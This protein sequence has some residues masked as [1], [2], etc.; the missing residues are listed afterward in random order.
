MTVPGEFDSIRPYNDEETVAALHRVARH[1]FYPLI[2]KYLF[3]NRTVADCRR[4]LL[5][6][7]GVDDFQKRVMYNVVKAII[8]KTTDGFS[9]SGIE[10]I[11]DIDGKFVAITNHRDIVLDPALLEYTLLD[12]GL[13]GSQIC[14]GNN[15]IKTQLIKDLMLS[16]RSITV[17]RNSNPRML[18]ERSRL[19]SAY[20]RNSVTC[21]GRAVWI[22]QREGRAKDGNDL[23]AQ[24][25]LKMLNMSGEGNFVENF[26]E[27]K[28]VPMTYSYELESC[29]SRKAREIYIKS[30]NGFYKKGWM[31]DTMSI[32]T[33]IMQKKGKV[34]LNIG[35]P[36]SV[37]ELNAAAAMKGNDRFKE[38]CNILDERIAYGYH[39]WKTNY[40]AAD[41]VNGNSHYASKGM[42]T[43]EDLV[44]FTAYISKKIN[45]IEGRYR[46]DALR[47]VFLHIY[48]NPVK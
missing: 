41:I 22:A 33:G 30:V 24:G 12:S 4:E 20:I 21:D 34:H 18:V 1:P 29:D 31:E 36:V 6:I 40:M 42:Y 13:K 37:E 27:L 32:L 5:S 15:L 38:L 14:I 7:T 48:S 9:Y 35:K 8:D 46:T 45:K 3:P 39:L 11:R 26:S 2:V 44:E 47:D 10:N 17:V 43:T 16:N 19:L 23:T 25:V 28:L